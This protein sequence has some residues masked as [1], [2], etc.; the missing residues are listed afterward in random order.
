MKGEFLAVGDLLACTCRHTPTTGRTERHPIKCA[1][2]R[3]RE[4]AGAAAGA[5]DHPPVTTWRRCRPPEGAG[6]VS[7]KHCVRLADH[8]TLCVRMRLLFCFCQVRGAAVH[9]RGWARRVSDTA[10]QAMVRFP[11]TRPH[12]TRRVPSIAAPMT[13]APARWAVATSAAPAQRVGSPGRQAPQLPHPFMLGMSRGAMK[14]EASN[15]WCKAHRSR[16]RTA[17]TEGRARR[18][19]R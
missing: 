17:A 14:A 18:S 1:P 19:P 11:A 3:K 9:C 2:N 15:S 4:K 8:D 16:D 7:N 5:A 13:A 12:P 10:A 6:P